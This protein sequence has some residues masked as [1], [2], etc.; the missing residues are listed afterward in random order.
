MTARH[1]LYKSENRWAKAT[2]VQKLHS[3]FQ[4]KLN[5][6]YKDKTDLLRA[7]TKRKTQ[8]TL[9]YETISMLKKEEAQDH[10]KRFRDKSRT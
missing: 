7:L 2:E 8:A 3:I 10:D 9:D 4:R 5:A 6:L 1:S